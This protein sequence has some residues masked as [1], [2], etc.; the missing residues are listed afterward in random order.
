M[1]ENTAAVS[2]IE[3]PAARRGLVLD[4]VVLVG[5]M[6][7]EYRRFFS[8]DLDALHGRTVLDV[9]SGVSSFCVEANALGIRATACDAIYELD[10]AVIRA[11]CARDLEKVTRAMSG[12]QTYRW[13]TIGGLEAMH[14]LREQAYLKFL[15]DYPA[16]RGT[17]YVPGVLPVLPFADRSF[18]LTLCSYLLFVYEEHFD[19][20]FHR[21]SLLEIMRVTRNEARF[22]PTVNYECARSEHLMRML[23]DKALRHLRFE[24]VPTDFEFLRNSNN[25]LHVTRK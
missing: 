8:L 14:G 7:D 16:Q 13:E 10:H 20:E 9:A 15:A 18:D 4:E 21:Q 23:E 5:R 11:R 2:E 6:L 25:C 22:Y 12:L 17:R 3:H 19:Y 24:I 1:S